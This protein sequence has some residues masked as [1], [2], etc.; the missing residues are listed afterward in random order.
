MELES[1]ILSEINQIQPNNH[2]FS[3]MQNIY[4]KKYTEMEGRLFGGAEDDNSK[5]E[6][7]Q[8][9]CMSENATMTPIIFNNLYTLIK[10]F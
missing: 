5:G 6:Y 9:M 1:I 10:V 8:S 4:F 3:H 2:I 7:D